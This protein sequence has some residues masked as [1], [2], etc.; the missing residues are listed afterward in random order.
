MAVPE[1]TAQHW[2]ACWFDLKVPGIARVRSR[3]RYG[4]RYA[5]DPDLIERWRRCALPE[6][7]PLP[8]AA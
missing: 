5:V 8:R 1:R 7:R 6:P 3:G 2:L 4:F